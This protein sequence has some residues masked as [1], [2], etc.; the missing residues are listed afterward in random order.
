MVDLTHFTNVPAE[1]WI[2]EWETRAP[3]VDGREEMVLQ[4]Y[5]IRKRCGRDAC[6]E[7]RKYIKEI[8]HFPLQK[9]R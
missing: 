8:G 6:W 2:S 5:G 3:S 9:Q 1:Q 4:L 7:Y